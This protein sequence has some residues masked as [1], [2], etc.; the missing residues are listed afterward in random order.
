MQ[1]WAIYID[2]EGTAKIYEQDEI[3][4]FTSFNALTDCVC[5]IGS[6][7]YPRTPSRLFVHQV[8]GDG[9]VIVS[10]FREGSPE[11]PLAIGVILMQSVLVA[12]GVAKSG[13]SQGTFAD[14]RACVPALRS[15][16]AE[17]GRLRLGDG[18]MTVFPVMGTALINAH[19][20]ATG[21]PR[22]ARLAVDAAMV[23]HMPDGVVL[24]HSETDF[25]IVDWVHT[26]TRETERILSD[27]GI[28]IP[29]V[30]ELQERLL[31]YVASTGSATN[32]EWKRYTLSLN[33]CRSA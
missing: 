12:G 29:S 2:L 16:P 25:I 6:R 30:G 20:L 1:R 17:D 21:E 23:N 26:R 19:R 13:I 28:E 14:V 8:G 31:A 33:G 9:F 27:A 11:V 32:E 4:F 5:R 3:R 7:A 18:I 15:Y 10:E 22:G 24:A